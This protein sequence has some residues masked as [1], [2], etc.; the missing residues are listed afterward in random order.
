MFKYREN[1]KERTRLFIVGILDEDTLRLSP[2]FV[3]IYSN[4][5]PI[6]LSTTLNPNIIELGFYFLLLSFQVLFIFNFDI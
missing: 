1:G 2:L 5:V 4:A 6:E 3:C